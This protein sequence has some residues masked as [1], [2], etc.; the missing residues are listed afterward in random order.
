M[1]FKN[2]TY[3]FLKDLVL[4]VLPALATFIATVFK[5]WNI[6]YGI[7][8]SATIT[9]LTTALG[10]ALKISNNKY[11]KENGVQEDEY[12]EEL[13]EEEEEE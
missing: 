4:Y 8:I 2:E 9:A 7:E 3:D 12:G 13:E 1:K 10:V 11:K 5:I 6:P